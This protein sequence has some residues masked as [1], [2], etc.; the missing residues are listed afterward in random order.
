[1]YE[2]DINAKISTN[3][4]DNKKNIVTGLFDES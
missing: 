4:L 1:M 2:Q 3:F